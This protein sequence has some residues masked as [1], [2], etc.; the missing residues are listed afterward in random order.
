MGAH[1][2]L[3]GPASLSG[4]QLV[5]YV[6]APVAVPI[7]AGLQGNNVVLSWSGTWVLQER[8]TV[9]GGSWTDVG[10]ATS[11]YTVPQPLAN[12]MFFRLRSP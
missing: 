8:G 4:F 10:G 2:D 11:P 12:M 9:S 1:P 6:A 3:P 7:H 5:A